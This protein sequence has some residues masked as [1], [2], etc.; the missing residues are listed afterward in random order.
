MKG[1]RHRKHED[2]G[3]EMAAKYNARG[4]DFRAALQKNGSANERARPEQQ[5]KKRSSRI[6]GGMNGTMHR[7]RKDIKTII[8][9][10]L[11]ELIQG[12]PML[13]CLRLTCHSQRR[14]SGMG[15]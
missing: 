2:N 7:K 12:F 9:P 3:F 15:H 11:R 6:N 4:D 1:S 8:G 13:D 10:N 5:F 14:T